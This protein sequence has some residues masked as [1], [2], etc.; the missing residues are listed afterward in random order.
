MKPS[1]AEG[2]WRPWQQVL[3]RR[4]SFEHRLMRLVVFGARRRFITSRFALLHQSIIVRVL[5]HTVALLALYV[6]ESF[7]FV[8]LVSG[9]FAYTGEKPLKCSEC[10]TFRR[11]STLCQHMKKHRGIRNHVATFANKGFT[12]F[13]SEKP[14]ECQYCDRR[15]T[16]QS[17]LIYHRRT[18][19]GEKPYSCKLCPA[20]FTTSSARNN[21]VLT[22]TGTKK[23]VCTICYRV[24]P[25]HRVA[26]P[27]EQAHRLRGQRHIQK[28][29]KT[30][31]AKGET[32]SMNSE[33]SAE[34][35]VDG[36]RA[37][38]RKSS[39]APDDEQPDQPPPATI[40]SSRR[41]RPPRRKTAARR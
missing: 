2:P 27:R 4:T 11:H 19:T 30:H 15:F 38:R 26:G 31:E 9:D 13:P 33:N 14:F 24:A 3:N 21:H 28:H 34:A 1:P 16:Q 8:L 6:T 23:Y 22:H 20:R 10:K 29:L 17:A 25:P 39:Q 32:D 35:A 7:S 12:R 40:S 41:T 5:V 36:T 37:S 18:H